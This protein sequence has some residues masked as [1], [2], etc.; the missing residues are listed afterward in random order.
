MNRKTNTLLAAVAVLALG[1]ADA[2]VAQDTVNMT[3]QDQLLISQI[4]TDKRAVVLKTMNLS[5]DQM[6]AFVPVY[7]Q[8]QAEMKKL[9]QRNGD[10]VNKYAATYDSMTDADAKKL[11]DEAFKLRKERTDVLA[12]YARKLEKVLPATKVLRFVQ[13][14]NKLTTLLDWQAVQLIPLAK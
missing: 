7:D 8:Y 11:L 1:A 2:A 12:K 3:D 5:D 6:K 10:L 14:E 13:I 9:V 4:Q